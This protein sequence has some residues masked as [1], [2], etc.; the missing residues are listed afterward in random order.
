LDKTPVYPILL[1]KFLVIFLIVKFLNKSSHSS[2]IKSIGIDKALL[3][4][5][6]AKDQQLI[7]YYKDQQIKSCY[8]DNYEI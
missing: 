6:L 3:M 5:I 4:K 1:E 8:I 2:K 7:E